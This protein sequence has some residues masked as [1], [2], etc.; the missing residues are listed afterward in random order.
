MINIA[1]ILKDCPKG[2]KLY[3]PICGDCT[4]EKIHLNTSIVVCTQD[5]RTITFNVYGQY[6]RDFF[7]NA[8]CLLFPSKENR[9]WTTFQKPFKDGDILV[10]MLGEIFIYQKITTTDFCGSYAS[11]N[12]HGKFSPYYSSFIESSARFATENE[13]QKF[14]DAM[15]ANGYRWNAETKTI[16]QIIPKKFDI[17]TLKPFDKVLVRHLN[18]N[19]WVASFFSHY[20]KDLKFGCYPFVTTSLK[21]FPKCIPYEGNE[22]LLGTTCDCEEFYKTWCI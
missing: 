1:K 22:Y 17:S 18:D 14:F 12:I 10:T 8:E 5:C 15:E 9:D 7:N 19:V 3:S 4:F 6:F 21:S 20:E 2:T 13:K 11:L 16:G